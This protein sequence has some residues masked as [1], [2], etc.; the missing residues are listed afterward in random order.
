M[1]SGRTTYISRLVAGVVA[2]VI[3]VGFGAARA[4]AHAEL[5]STA[6]ADGGV[7]DAGPAKIALTFSESVE[8][9]LGGIKL[10]D[11]NAK[12]VKIGPTQHGNGDASIVEATVPTLANGTYVVSWRAISSD[13]H[14]VF[15]AFTFR[16]GQGA[17]GDT[18][19][20]RA[21][22]LAGGGASKA[23]GA[24]LGITR[25]A[26]FASLATLIGLALFASLL[27]PIGTERRVR[28]VLWTAVAVALVAALAGIGFQGAYASGASLGQ[29]TN[30]ALWRAVAKTRF[31]TAALLRVALLGVASALVLQFAR[32]RHLVWR[33]GAATV[34]VG[35]LV[36]VAMAGHATTGLHPAVGMAADLVH[37]GA[38]SVWLGGLVG[39][40]IVLAS[41]P[42][43]RAIGAAVNTNANTH[44][45]APIGTNVDTVDGAVAVDIDDGEQSIEGSEPSRRELT[46]RFS[47][48]ALGSVAALVA[49]GTVQSWRQVGSLAGLWT[50]YGHLLLWKLAAVAGV[51][52]LAF[53]SRRALR[54]WRASG[55]PGG[56]RRSVTGELAIGLVVLAITA[57]LVAARP[58]RESISGPVT[59][60]LVATDTQA[61]LTI[62]PAR[63][64]TAAFHLYLAPP[65][66][67]LQKVKSASL[68]LTLES[69][70]VG[71]LE[72]KLNPAGANHYTTESGFIPL[73]GRWTVQITALLTDF[74]ER[75]FTT[76]VNVT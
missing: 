27:A 38:A 69:Q 11:A 58:G 52:A 49:S 22:A 68:Q 74:D 17:V 32:R 72:I 57:A 60:N 29:V 8:V 37:L 9:A 1:S 67:S 4:D 24:G 15:G 45:F 41:P 28:R 36:S 3:V 39:L 47:R 59:V 30:A 75:R 63:H 64:G 53:S 14:P 48:I 10:L 73:P 71:P 25:L 62:D 76:T 2:V 46:M 34:A 6:P 18:N 50:G 13:S 51:V 55:G 43:A 7:L 26:T 66:G 31:G 23:V 19:A 42:R 16:V 20:L 54:R 35:L 21:Q 5:L 33:V 44:T 61:T 40:A 65:G 12:P 56:L 70:G